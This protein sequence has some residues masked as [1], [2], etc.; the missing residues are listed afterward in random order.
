[1]PLL[2]LSEARVRIN[3]VNCD[4]A[5][6]AYI[7]FT[8]GSI[9]ITAQVER[10]DICTRVHTRVHSCI[11]RENIPPFSPIFEAFPLETT[12]ISVR[13]YRALARPPDYCTYNGAVSRPALRF[14]QNTSPTARNLNLNDRRPASVREE[15]VNFKEYQ[16]ALHHLPRVNSANS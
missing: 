4:Y 9:I 2:N 14:P 3:A 6:H 10:V 12:E 11:Q 7:M 16:Q 5:E 8:V 13:F 1:M 15:V